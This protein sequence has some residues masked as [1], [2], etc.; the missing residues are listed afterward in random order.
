MV[1]AEM[2][3]C[4]RAEAEKFYH[5]YESTSAEDENGRTVWQVGNL[6]VGK[7][8]SLLAK[9]V[10]NWQERASKSRGPAGANLNVAPVIP[11]KIDL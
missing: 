10:S 1:R 5:H 4:S 2:S 7:W 9:W 8:T 11:R 6:P 3:G